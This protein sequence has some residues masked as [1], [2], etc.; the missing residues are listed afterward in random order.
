LRV[1]GTDNNSLYRSFG[2]TS[3]KVIL[4][5]KDVEALKTLQDVI[6]LKEIRQISGYLDGK[7]VIDEF[8]FQVKQVPIFDPRNAQKFEKGMSFIFS[9][10]QLVLCQMF[11]ENPPE[12][13]RVYLTKYE[14]VV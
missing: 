11:Y 9:N 13:D 5:T 10:G 3:T 7:N 12:A 8:T 2:S 1:G 14:N 6:P 4:S